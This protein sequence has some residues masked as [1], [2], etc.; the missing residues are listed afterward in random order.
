MREHVHV[1][2]CVLTQS[3]STSVGYWSS[4]YSA[5]RDSQEMKDFLGLE[6][7]DKCLGFFILGKCKEPEKYRSS[8]GPISKKVDWRI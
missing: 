5:A 1:N 8:R 3:A 2:I 4:W 6:P 7:A